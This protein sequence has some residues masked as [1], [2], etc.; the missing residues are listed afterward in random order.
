[1]AVIRPFKGVRPKNEIAD[2]VASYPYDVINSKE[3]MEIAGENPLSFLHVVKPEIDLSEDINL[4]DERVYQK[5]KENFENMLKDGNL[6]QDEKPH[7]Y[8]YKQKMGDH[9]QYGIIGCASADEYNNN[10]IKKHEFTRKTKEDDRTKHVI[11]LNANT[12]PV[13]LTYRNQDIID[14]TIS[15]YVK[16]NNPDVDFIADDGIEHTLW[17]INDDSIN[18][19]L[20]NTFKN[21]VEYLYVADGHHRSASAARAQTEKIKN[22]KNPDSNKEYNYFLAVYFPANQLKILDYNRVLFSLNGHEPENFLE[23][24]QEKFD[25]ISEDTTPDP[26][27]PKEFG[28][29]FGGKW[30]Q[31]RAKV[32]TYPTDDPVKCL[33]VAILQDNLLSPILGIGDPRTDNNI[34]FVGG[35]RGASELVKRVDSGECKVAFK[36]HPTSVDQLISVADADKIM[37]PKSTW[38][39]PKLR[40]GLIV[41]LLD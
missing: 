17:V 20:V 36:L 35:I 9:Q 26:K 16:S 24:L 27:S 21:N 12:G 33:D 4:Y 30:Y 19:K 2:K 41:H 29:Y 40:S 23:K 7:L 5:A 18:T 10:I 6:V 11:T 31:L 37:P 3:A 28:M 8:I 32:G 1:M 14:S 34:D 25:I 15:E 13:F 22:D 39:E 38:F